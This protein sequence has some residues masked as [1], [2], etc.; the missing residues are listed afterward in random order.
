MFSLAR[1]NIENR[2]KS[3]AEMKNSSEIL[4]CISKEMHI[5]MENIKSHF[6]TDGNHIK[7]KLERDF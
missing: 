2:L 5:E 7:V 1:Q 3:G 6:L 4:A